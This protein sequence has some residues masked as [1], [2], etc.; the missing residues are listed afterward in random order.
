M[1]PNFA[2]DN[3]EQLLNKPS[4][5]RAHRAPAARTARAPERRKQCTK[6]LYMNSDDYNK[7]I[8]SS[9]CACIDFN[10]FFMMSDTIKN[11]SYNDG[12]LYFDFNRLREAELELQSLIQGSHGKGG[13][14]MSCPASRTFKFLP[15][16]PPR[17]DGQDDDARKESITQKKAELFRAVSDLLRRNG[18]TSADNPNAEFIKMHFSRLGTVVF[19][20]PSDDEPIDQVIA[21]LVWRKLLFSSIIN[22]NKLGFTP[23][24]FPNPIIPFQLV[25]ELYFRRRCSKRHPFFNKLANML[26][27]TNYFPEFYSILGVIWVNG[28]Y[29]KV[30]RNIFGK[31]INN[32]SSNS[33]LFNNSGIFIQH[34]F[35]EVPEAT[36]RAAVD[37]G[38]ID[39]VDFNKVRV[40]TDTKENFSRFFIPEFSDYPF[41]KNCKLY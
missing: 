37:V 31:T 24:T 36:V 13:A 28:H 30:N 19:D 14:G 23:H 2:Y 38:D 32:N 20:P 29:F 39:D 9:S 25:F 34:G 10:R 8:M 7:Y 15:S 17:G 11:I 41:N 40:L 21:E 4:T 18:I 5:H 35:T 12:F 33:A 16:A 26:R 6:K 22:L 1:N 27:I 3:L